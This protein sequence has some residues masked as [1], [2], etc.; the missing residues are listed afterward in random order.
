MIKQDATV[1]CCKGTKVGMKNTAAARW[2]TQTCS[3]C[4]DLRSRFHSRE[5]YQGQRVES[6]NDVTI[7]N[8][9]PLSKLQNTGNPGSKP[10]RAARRNRQTCIYKQPSQ[11]QGSMSSLALNI[12][13]T[14]LCDTARRKTRGEGEKSCSQLIDSWENPEASAT[15][16]LELTAV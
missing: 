3:G 2:L 7:L 14:G 1:L 10:D 6:S 11:G 4:A 12:M 16:L 13:A 9:M 15:K 8:I 5:C